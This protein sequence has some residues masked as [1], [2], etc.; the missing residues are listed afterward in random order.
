M[1][2]VKIYDAKTKVVTTIPASELAPG[3][4]RVNIE[5]VG[6]VFIEAGAMTYAE[7]KKL[8]DGFAEMATAVYEII[9]PELNGRLDLKGWIEG[10]Q[11]DAHPV[12]ELT[13]WMTAT[14]VYY[15]MTHKGEDTADVRRD[16][17]NVCVSAMT[18]GRQ[19]LEVVELLR[20]SKARAQAVLDRYAALTETEWDAFW[21]DRINLRRWYELR[22]AEV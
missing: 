18:N 4:I 21:E 1:N 10:F 2:L 12:T 16:V 7:E 15:E 6:E 19:A 5:G 9:G 14:V 17:F 22:A 13:T 8:P 3:M 11:T 20:L